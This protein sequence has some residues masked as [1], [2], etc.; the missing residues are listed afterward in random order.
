MKKLIRVAKAILLDREGKVLIYLRDDKP[1][2]PY[3]N[4]WDLIGGTL[5]EGETALEGLLRETIEE[6]DVHLGQVNPFVEYYTDENEHFTI[7]WAQIDAIAGELHLTEGQCLTS[8][9]LAERTHYHF[10][11]KLGWVLEQFAIMTAGQ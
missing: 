8:I 4:H 3:P 7:F 2:I 10:A 11:G 9:E 6:I 5:E 1:T